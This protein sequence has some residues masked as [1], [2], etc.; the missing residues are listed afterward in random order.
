[1]EATSGNGQ[2]A[3]AVTAPQAVAETHS[4]DNPQRTSPE[5]QQVGASPAAQVPTADRGRGERVRTSPLVKRLA[6]DHGI[7]L[8]EVP[9]TG[10]GGRVSKQDIMSF[11]E[12]KEQAP[13]APHLA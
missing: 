8:A 6:E 4:A 13:A 10:I 2:S 3:T 11:I 5:A 1:Q 7:N 9:G 12:Q